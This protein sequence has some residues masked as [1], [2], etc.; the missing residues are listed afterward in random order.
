MRFSTCIYFYKSN[1]YRSLSK[2]GRP[3]KPVDV[4]DILDLRALNYKWTKIA[5]I[6]GI[7]RATLY[8]RLEDSGISPDDYTPLSDEQLDEVICTIKR[9]HPND[10]EV[11]LC[12]HL[13]RKGIR[14]TRQAVR[15]SIHRVDHLNVVKRRRSVIKRRIY[16]VPHPNYIWHIDGHHKLIRWRFV[17]HGSIDGFSRTITYLGCSDNN[18]SQTVLGL[19][20]DAVNQFGLPHQVR[21]DHGG[22]NVAVWRNMIAAHNH[23]FSCVLTGSSVHNQR[24][25][26]LWRDVRRCV[27]STFADTF[28]KLESDGFL[29]PLNE[30]D[31]YCLHFVFL[32]RIQRCVTEFRESWNH[33]TLSSEGNMTP[34]QLF[35][36]GMNHIVTNNDYSLESNVGSNV[37]ID[38]SGEHVTVP[39]MK[40]VPC[41]SLLQDLS[42]INQLQSSPDNGT[43]LYNNVIQKAGQHLCTTCSQCVFLS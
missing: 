10:G 23:D 18:R 9:D 14:V 32:P 40:F 38:T 5:T 31:L 41:A 30:V 4:D 2:V 34:Y 39:R 8:R 29:D 25:E 22:E 19:F 6:L 21:S 15:N 24:V 16:S 26:R 13:T 28:R 7:S 42:S 35:Y 17:I 3:P 1:N 36:E 11:L 12:G 43:G 20:H 27:V 37:D 33:H